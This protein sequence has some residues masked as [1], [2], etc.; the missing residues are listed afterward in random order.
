M[1]TSPYL[2]SCRKRCL[3]VIV[4][5][6]LLVPA[7]VLMLPVLLAVLL[8][9]G[10]PVILMQERIG[11]A[12]RIFR[13]PKFRTMRGNRESGDLRATWIG[14]FLRKHRLDELPQIFLVLSGQMSL[15]GP[16]PELVDIVAGYDDRQIRRLAAQS[17]VTGIWQIRADR[18]RRIHEDIGYDLYYL[19]KAGLWL[20]VKILLRTISFVVLPVAG[21][22]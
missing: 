6:I 21:Q 20:D 12:G 10:H 2:G 14:S 8:F 18:S 1:W 22:A 19:R 5:L 13:M 16:R 4:S 9:D 7:A 17:G 3:D 15:V 11:Q